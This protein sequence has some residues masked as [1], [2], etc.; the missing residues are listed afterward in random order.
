[1]YCYL[2][3][4]LHSFRKLL[5]LPLVVSLILSYFSLHFPMC[6]ASSCVKKV[7]KHSYVNS[8][9]VETLQI[10]KAK[11]V[12]KG[13]LRVE[14]V[15]ELLPETMCLLA[16]PAGIAVGYLYL[17]SHPISS[18]HPPALFPTRASPAP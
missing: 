15:A 17:V 13:I 14:S 9:T 4:S 1:M 8:P 12:P 6:S 16:E 3:I 10:A 5:L 18:Y 7:P 11:Q 2:Q